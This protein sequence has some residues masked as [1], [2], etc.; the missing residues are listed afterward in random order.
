M[1]NIR[2]QAGYMIEIPI[3]IAVVVVLLWI[4][5]PRLPLGGAKGT[6]ISPR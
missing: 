2:K 3:G 4:L 6:A 5:V 1:R